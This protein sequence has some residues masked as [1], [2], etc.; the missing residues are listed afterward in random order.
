M[1]RY[2]RGDYLYLGPPTAK[3]GPHN[4][5]LNTATEGVVSVGHYA[6]LS[7]I[8]VVPGFVNEDYDVYGP[9]NVSL[10]G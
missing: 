1:A 7:T 9:F 10:Q 4:I 6:L 8:Y 5:P 3:R 2:Y